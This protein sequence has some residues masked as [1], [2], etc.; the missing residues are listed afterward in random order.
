MARLTSAAEALE[1]NL[2]QQ[3]V[4]QRQHELA[5]ETLRR[6]EAELRQRVHLAPVAIG[7]LPAPALQCILLTAVRTDN[8]LRYVAACASVCA[9]WRRVV[10]GSAA[11]GLGLP[12]S[13]SRPVPDYSWLTKHHAEDDDERARVLKTITWGLEQ[14]PVHGLRVGH[15]RV[16]AGMAALGAALQAMPQI[17]FTRLDVGDGDLSAAGVASLVPALRRPWGDGGL[18]RFHVN[19]SG[20]D[21]RCSVGDAGMKALTGVLPPTLEW[22]SFEGTGC[23]DDGFEALAVALPALTQLE[24]LWCGDNPGVGARGWTALAG[25]LPSLPALREV[26]A[27][28]NTQLEPKGAAALLAAVP[29]CSS[30]ASCSVNLEGL[31]SEI[32]VAFKALTRDDD[33]PGG[34]LKMQTWVPGFESFGNHSDDDDDDDDDDSEDEQDASSDDE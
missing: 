30:L 17:R 14:D 26:I 4:Q 9:T 8:L 11:Y 13:R 3:R 12:R 25:A 28:H 21:R 27:T 23:S 16:G 6:Q 5:M 20:S 33:H 1:A 10:A 18:R 19:C 29:R 7:D 22:L 24:L 31:A 32:V 2:E 34:K 15:L